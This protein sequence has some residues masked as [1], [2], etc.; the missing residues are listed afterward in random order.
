MPDQPMPVPP[1]Y[2]PEV[3]ARAVLWAAEHRRREIYVGVPTVYTILGNKIAPWLAER[4]LA[5]TAYKGQQ[6]QGQP[7]DPNR[8]SNLFAPVN[9]D[10]GAHGRYDDKAHAHSAQAFLSRHRIGAAV[11]A[12]GVAAAAIS[13][14][15][16]RLR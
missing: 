6:V 16:E 15:S 10:P 2:Q 9:G 1:I 13:S 12:A 5:K 7:V 4:Y 11:A 14:R 3:A 8:P